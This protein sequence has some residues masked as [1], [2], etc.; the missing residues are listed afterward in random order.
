MRKPFEIERSTPRVLNSSWSTPESLVVIDVSRDGG[1]RYAKEGYEDQAAFQVHRDLHGGVTAIN[2]A[3][4]R[5]SK[6]DGRR[7]CEKI[8][9]PGPVCGVREAV[10]PESG[11]FALGVRLGIRIHD[12]ERDAVARGLD[13]AH[14]LAPQ[15]AR[16]AAAAAMR[17]HVDLLVHAERVI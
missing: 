16:V 1:Q 3:H 9:A 5:G 4:R 10:F 12:V 15:L 8:P 11:G 7:N 6:F 14:V 2:L 17:D 13:D